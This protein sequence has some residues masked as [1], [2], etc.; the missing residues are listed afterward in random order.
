MTRSGRRSSSSV[1]EPRIDLIMTTSMR[2]LPILPTTVIGSLPRPAWLID[3][4]P[5]PSRRA[6]LAHGVGPRLRPGDSLRRGASG[7]RGD[8]RH[9]RWR[10]AAEGYFQVFYERV[11]GFR[12]DLIPGRTRPLAA[13]VGPLVRGSDR[14]GW[15]GLPARLTDRRS[16]SVCRVAYVILRR[17][18]SPEHSARSTRSKTSTPWKRSCSRRLKRC[19]KSQIA[20]ITQHET[21]TI[22]GRAQTLSFRSDPHS[23]EAAQRLLP[24]AKPGGRPR[25]VKLREIINGIFSIARGG[26][27]GG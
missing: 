11:E 3:V 16:T 4:L 26:C 17:F 2:N 25:E 13:A 22:R 14:G 15:S 7:G 12:A 23:V 5:G 21:Q 20:P 8:R 18:Y 24:P 27:R 10:V 19:T 9:L 6:H 1:R